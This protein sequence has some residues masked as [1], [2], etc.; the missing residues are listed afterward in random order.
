[1]PSV[2]ATQWFMQRNGCWSECFYVNI[3]GKSTCYL[4]FPA[5]SF[6]RDF[7]RFN[8][9]Y[10]LPITRVSTDTHSLN[11]DACMNVQF[12]ASVREKK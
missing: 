2:D 5:I 9:V 10:C 11:P 1:M 7:Q 6:W 8:R 12:T 4:E 3:E